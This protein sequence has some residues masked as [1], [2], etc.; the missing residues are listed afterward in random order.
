MPL[1]RVAKEQ[2]VHSKS[3]LTLSTELYKL[4]CEE[5]HRFCY[6]ILS[7][8]NTLAGVGSKFLTSGKKR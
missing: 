8:T 2:C 3:I 1:Y 4:T 5:E 6:T 7:S